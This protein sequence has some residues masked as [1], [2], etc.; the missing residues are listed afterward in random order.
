MTDKPQGKV[1]PFPNGRAPENNGVAIRAEGNVTFGGFITTIDCPADRTL[2]QAKGN[3]A[4]AIV[5]GY[6]DHGDLYFASS[7]S[8]GGAVLW[9]LEQAKKALL[10][11]SE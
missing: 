9:T 11:I 5:I 1:L 3:L 7:Q 6:D 8:D 4:T 2:E 10:D